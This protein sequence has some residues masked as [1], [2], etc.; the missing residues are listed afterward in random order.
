MRAARFFALPVREPDF[1]VFLPH[2]YVI[3]DG[4]GGYVAGLLAYAGF[5]WAFIGTV[6]FKFFAYGFTAMLFFGRSFGVGYGLI[7]VGFNLLLFFA[8]GQALAGYV[9]LALTN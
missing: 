3:M 5:F 2:P 6:V 8:V 1:P 4:L 9:G 7:Y